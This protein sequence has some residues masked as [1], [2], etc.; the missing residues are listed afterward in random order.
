VSVTTPSRTASGCCGTSSCTCAACQGLTTLVRPRFFSGQVLT[1]TDLTALERYTIDTHRMHNRY[2]H[3]PGVVC[4]LELV[5]EDC[6]DGIAIRPGYGLDPCGRDLVVPDVQHVD[7]ARMIRDCIAAQRATPSCDPPLTGPPKGCDIDE[8]WCVTLC[9]REQPMRPM[10]PLASSTRT[11]AASGCGA[12]AGGCG[13]SDSSGH[14]GV[15][16]GCGAGCTEFVAVADLP[17]GCEPTRIAECF[18]I[19]VHRCED[20]CCGI[21]EV[22][23]DTF[24]MKAIACVRTLLPLFTKRTTTRQQTA[25]VG[26]AIG[27]VGDDETTRTGI[28]ELWAS[29]YELYT[30]DPLRTT[31]QMPKELEQV[32]CSP[33]GTDETDDAYRE[34]LV[35]S[36]QTLVLLV[37][38]YL[39]DCLCH[40]INPTCSAPCDDRI[41][42]GC[43][44][45]RDGKVLDICNLQCRQYAGS[46]VSR[47]YWLPVL[48][49]VMWALGLL[50]CFPLV[51]R[52]SNGRL[53]M[54]RAMDR[55]DPSRSVRTLLAQDDFK[56][57][58]NVRKS[59]ASTIA[60]LRPA[61]L[62][63]RYAPSASAVN[64][65]L[66]QGQS[67]TSAEKALRKANVDVETVEVSAAE[68]DAGLKGT[69]R[70]PVAEP[71]DKIVQFVHQGKVLAFGRAAKTEP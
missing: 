70:F 53:A 30:R 25:L 46:F 12:P 59:A 60:G 6:G 33:R 66:L 9:Y 16:N 67:K 38:S 18:E 22:L 57:V 20:D 51:G 5:C 37:V 10:T 52:R 24:P 62:R 13:C 63:E 55:A 2:L 71:G 19:G 41:V 17:P 54:A 39:R 7:V 15:T 69:L 43:L 48:P 44:T 50:C 29:V 23:A 1:E 64:L 36:S 28:C 42:L 40:A 45:W 32:D 56:L 31:C 65:A 27:S 21:A 11:K 61:A 34:R 49:A 58:S 35:A 8:R 68:V 4:G 3:G 26:A 47:R 14:A